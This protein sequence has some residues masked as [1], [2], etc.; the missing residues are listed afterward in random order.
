MSF[1]LF[2]LMKALQRKAKVEHHVI[3]FQRDPQELKYEC[4]VCNSNIRL[5]LF[6]ISPYF[7][8][9]LQSHWQT[10]GIMDLVGTHVKKWIN[11]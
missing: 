10:V 8:A 11:K 4:L 5:H 2:F 7:L 3:D 9:Y 1:D 6:L